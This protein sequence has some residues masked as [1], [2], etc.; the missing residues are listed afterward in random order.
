MRLRDTEE[1]SREGRG[2]GM[3]L[4]QAKEHLEMPEADRGRKMLLESLWREHGPAVSRLASRTVSG[5]RLL[6][7]VASIYTGL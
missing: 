6:S 7:S 3:M 1:E 4:P 2:R 5:V